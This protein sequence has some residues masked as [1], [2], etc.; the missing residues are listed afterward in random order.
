VR[1]AR[2]ATLLPTLGPDA[3]PVVSNRLKDRRLGELPGSAEAELLT[4]FWAMH[5]PEQAGR[6]ALGASPPEFQLA[7][8][9]PAISIWAAVD[10]SSASERVRGVAQGTQAKGRAAQVA[11]VRGWMSSGKP[12]LDKYMKS[13]TRGM[14]QQRLI[15][16][17]FRETLERDG[18]EAVVHWAESL[19][20]Q[21]KVYKLDAF[22]Q[23]GSVL[24]QLDHEAALQFCEA[25]CD[26][27]YGSSLRQLI[28]QRWAERDG[29]ASLQWLSTSPEGDERDL[30]VRTTFLVWQRYE[31]DDAFS[32][33]VAKGPKKIE[34]WLRPAVVV[35]AK[36]LAL[37]APD[38]A[39]IWTEVIPRKKEREVTMIRIAG[40]WYGRDQGAAEAWLEQSPLSPE[41]REEARRKGK[42]EGASAKP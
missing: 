21:P 18:P 30:A 23:V 20:D 13:L 35:Y 32:W 34:P 11:L 25:H 9:P 33:L 8:I 17:F 10:P 29:K 38:E 40:Q 6:W 3:V 42:A 36:V 27:P 2:L 16:T 12:G 26:G 37:E 24:G 14:E 19:P 5:Q 41:Q 7:V 31:R 15:A 39:I 1:V 28:A 4:R 22:R